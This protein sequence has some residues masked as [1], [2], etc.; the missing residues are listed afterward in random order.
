M[1]DPFVTIYQIVFQLTM[2]QVGCVEL[3]NDMKK[4]KHTLSLFE[5]IEKSTNAVNIIFPWMPTIALMKRGAA[6]AKLYFSI[7]NIIADRKKTGRREKDALQYLLDMN[8][9]TKD[10]LQVRLSSPLFFPT[11]SY[12]D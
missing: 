9:E 11:K 10:I 6:G 2:R 12:G 4:L 1:I 8:D 5:A 3:A 7:K